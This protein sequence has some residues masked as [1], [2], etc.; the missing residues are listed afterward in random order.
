MSRTGTPYH[1]AIDGKIGADMSLTPAAD[2]FVTQEEGDA[3]LFVPVRTQ[4]GSI[5]IETDDAQLIRNIIP[6]SGGTRK[7]SVTNAQS[8]VV[9]WKGYVQPKMLSMRLFSGQQVVSIPVECGLAALKYRAYNYASIELPV[10]KMLAFI[11]V[12]LAGVWPIRLF[13]PSI[14]ISTRS[15]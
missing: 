10:S 1:I 2:P 9:V 11:S 3:D 12:G 14:G 8:G 13:S 7:V 4:S 5:R 6:D 15:I